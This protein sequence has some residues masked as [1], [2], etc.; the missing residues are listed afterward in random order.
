MTRCRYSEHGEQCGNRFARPV[1]F[2]ECIYR[3]LNSPSL[4]SQ[5]NPFGRQSCQPTLTHR[6][7]A[8]SAGS[9]I[10]QDVAQAQ[11][12]VLFFQLCSDSASPRSVP[13][14][15]DAQRSRQFV[16]SESTF[17]FLI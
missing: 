4:Y 13:P 2:T 9:S 8:S 12:N 1:L 7:Q 16:S 11:M 5:F 17:L 3:R 15:V 6:Q 10:I 14:R